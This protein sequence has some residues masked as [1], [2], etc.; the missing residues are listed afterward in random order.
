M[1][2]TFLLYMEP[3][4]ITTHIKNYYAMLVFGL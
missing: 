3:V 2:I 1:K 4:K